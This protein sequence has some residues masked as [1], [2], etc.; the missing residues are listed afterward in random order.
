MI[1][2]NQKCISMLLNFTLFLKK[3]FSHISTVDTD[4]TLPMIISREAA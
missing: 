4:P 1:W 3:H 2:H